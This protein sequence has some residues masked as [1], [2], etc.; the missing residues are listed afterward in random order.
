MTYQIWR[1]SDSGAFA[2]AEGLGPEEEKAMAALGMKK[3]ADLKATTKEEAQ[4][5]FVAWAKQRQPEAKVV[6]SNRTKIESELVRH[7]AY[8]RKE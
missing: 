4:K 2:M 8:G 1:T 7:I 3:V 5:E 6:D